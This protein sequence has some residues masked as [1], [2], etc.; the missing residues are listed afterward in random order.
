M[1]EIKLF[2][3]KN[4]PYCKAVLQYQKELFAENPAFAEIPLRIIEESEEAA[5]ADSFDYYFVPT[6]Y[7][8]E[9]K[10]HEGAATKEIVKSI[11][12]RAL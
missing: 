8:E 9:E 11:F 10:V 1:K 5:Y 4:C 3:L 12:E 7:I 2:I 6:Y